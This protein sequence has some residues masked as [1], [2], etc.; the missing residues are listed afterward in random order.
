M[1]PK[2]A[3][4]TQRIACPCAAERGAVRHLSEWA[5]AQRCAIFVLGSG[6]R[7]DMS[8]RERRH[9]QYGIAHAPAHAA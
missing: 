3:S 2:N 5:Q 8:D 6:A 4:V 7:G 1:S 9:D